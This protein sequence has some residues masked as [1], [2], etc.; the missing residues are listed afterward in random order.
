VKAELAKYLPSHPDGWLEGLRTGDPSEKVAYRLRMAH[1]DAFRSINYSMVKL[2]SL[3]GME[4]TF[5][6]PLWFSDKLSSQYKSMYGTRPSEVNL[7]VDI[8]KGNQKTFQIAL[9]KYESF[10][11]DRQAWRPLVDDVVRQITSASQQ[12][13][14]Q[15]PSQ[16]SSGTPRASS[17]RSK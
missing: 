11:R 3:L 6:Y 12:A 13:P 8:F 1:P 10:K 2:V 16:S 15:P 9:D 4:I 7:T 14:S 5:D 17:S